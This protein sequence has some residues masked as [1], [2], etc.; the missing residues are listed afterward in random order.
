MR[1]LICSLA[2]ALS[3]A[4]AHAQMAPN[5][6]GPK[7]DGSVQLPNQW[8]LMPAGRHTALGDYPVQ[9]LVHPKGPFVAALHCG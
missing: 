1:S 5:F 7:P 4:V 9:A 3:V 8:R 6:P 2:V